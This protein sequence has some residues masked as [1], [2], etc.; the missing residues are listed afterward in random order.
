MQLHMSYNEVHQ[1]A[2]QVQQEDRR[3]LKETDSLVGEHVGEDLGF[4]IFIKEEI[5]LSFQKASYF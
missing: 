5:M 2:D 3:G 4:L 1:F